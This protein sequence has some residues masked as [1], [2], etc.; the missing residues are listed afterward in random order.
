MNNNFGTKGVSGADLDKELSINWLTHGIYPLTITGHT[1]EKSQK[2]SERLVLHMEG[3]PETDPN[4]KKSKES[5]NGGKTAKVPL[6]IYIT[7]DEAQDELMKRL[8]LVAEH[9][10]RKTE[11]DAAGGD[12]TSLKEYLDAAVPTLYNADPAYFKLIGKEY[13]NKEGKLRVTCDGLARFGFV[14]AASQSSTP[15]LNAEGEI[16]EVAPAPGSDSKTVMKFNMNDP[17][18]FKKLEESDA[19]PDA[20]SN[21]AP[22]T[23]GPTD[24]NG[25]P[26]KLW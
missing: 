20:P 9:L 13:M 17:Y 18:D 5:V 24:A 1:V 22:S 3:Q 8:S 19:A 15:V 11:I 6:S 4:F 14:K 10:G 16:I 12:A 21:S 2:G 26:K 25:Q 23:T 7:T